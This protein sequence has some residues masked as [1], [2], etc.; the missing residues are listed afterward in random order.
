MIRCLRFFFLGLVVWGLAS[1]QQVTTDPDQK[2]RDTIVGNAWLVDESQTNP[3][4]E[5]FVFYP[6]GRVLISD[7]EST[8]S[9]RNSV[10]TINN[11]VDKQ[12]YTTTS[13]AFDATHFSFFYGPNLTNPQ[14]IHLVR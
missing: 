5:K 8:W 4:S 2:L 10:F 12:T 3:S 13:P 9:Y 7:W 6:G 11:P 14:L 1:C